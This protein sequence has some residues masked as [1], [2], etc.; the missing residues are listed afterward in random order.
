M[1]PPYL[2]AARRAI[3]E[4]LATVAGSVAVLAAVV[5]IWAARIIQGRDMYVSELG[6]AGE[7]TAHWFEGALLLIAVGGSLIAYAARGI[8]SRMV[9]L[10]SWTP[11]MSIWA[12][13]GFFF[14]A[15][16]VTCTRG[17]PLPVGAAFTWQ[18]TIHIVVAVIAFAAA[19][20]AMLQISFAEGNRRLGRFSRACGVAVALIAGAGGMS[21]LLRFHTNIGSR[22]ELAATTIALAWL[23]VLGLAMT[24]RLRR[25]ASASERDPATSIAVRATAR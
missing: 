22:L 23:L 12:G 2:S 16:Q 3:I 5:I 15:S 20:L 17:C 1:A 6:A 13:C 11:A 21:S 18:D 4:M 14:V 9:L 25:T 19:C 8:R 7:P 10:A 24:A